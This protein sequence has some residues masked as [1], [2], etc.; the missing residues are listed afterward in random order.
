MSI[1]SYESIASITAQPIAASEKLLQLIPIVLDPFGG[2]VCKFISNLGGETCE[3]SKVLKV[4]K[5]LAEYNEFAESFACSS[6]LQ[7]ALLTVSAAQSDSVNTE[8]LN[9]FSKG[10][11]SLSNGHDSSDLLVANFELMVPF[12]VSGF[13]SSDLSLAEVS[14]SFLGKSMQTRPSQMEKIVNLI[15]T[16]SQSFKE[17]TRS[18]GTIFMRYMSFLVKSCSINDDSF[19]ACE[20]A[21]AVADIVELCKYGDILVQ[22]VAIELLEDIASTRAGLIYL[23]DH[24]VVAWL[25]TVACGTLVTSSTDSAESII[26]E[27][28]EPDPLLS[29]QAL[30]VLGAVLAKAVGVGFDLASRVSP[31]M[32]YHF[33]RCI[34]GYFEDGDES[35]RL[36]GTVK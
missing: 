4:L 13:A 27:I 6:S 21:G 9:L 18:N 32:L 20:S 28:V 12:A 1:T 22:I 23:C 15:Y 26:M 36:A 24:Q 29:S 16:S 19:R 10:F 33:L 31:D 35:Q 8:V 3:Y 11:T 25:V 7:S 14:A 5:I 34:R 17:Q 2:D 30:R